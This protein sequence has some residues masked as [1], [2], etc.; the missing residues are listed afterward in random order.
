MAYIPL[1]A[2]QRGWSSYTSKIYIL[3]ASFGAAGATPEAPVTRVINKLGSA[4]KSEL[5]LS[6]QILRWI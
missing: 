5:N 4:T 2:F 3:G 1:E 6:N